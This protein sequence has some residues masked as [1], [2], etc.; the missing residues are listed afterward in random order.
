MNVGDPSIRKHKHYQDILQNAGELLDY[1]CGSGDDLRALVADGYPQQQVR[2]FDI[3][4]DSINLGFD[5]Y[6]DR[7]A[8]VHHFL[9]A[10]SLPFPP[11]SFD[12]IYSGGVIHTFW[13]KKGINKYSANASAAL[14]PGGVFFGY[15]L[16]FTEEL[17]QRA[18]EEDVQAKWGRGFFKFLTVDQLHAVLS[19]TGFNTIDVDEETRENEVLLSFYAEKDK[20]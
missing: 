2:G 8:R 3:N 1:G 20:E 12:V 15:S 11:P 5:L 17:P 16:G 18:S 6:L 13:T 14:K 9:V 4:W 7:E 19:A 10:D